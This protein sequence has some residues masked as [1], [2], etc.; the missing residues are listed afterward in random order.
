MNGYA[1][2]ISDDLLHESFY[3]NVN[4][5]TGQFFTCLSPMSASNF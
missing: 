1:V 2:V 5:P 3:S 4:R